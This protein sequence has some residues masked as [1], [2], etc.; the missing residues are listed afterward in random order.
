MIAYRLDKDM[1]VPL[2]QYDDELKRTMFAIKID[3]D[4]RLLSGPL[5]RK[6]PVVKRFKP[7]V[8]SPRLF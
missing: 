2:S 8:P 5:L 1:R 3:A 6:E 4:H 7:Y